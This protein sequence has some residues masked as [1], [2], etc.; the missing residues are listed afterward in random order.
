MVFLKKYQ[1]N[2]YYNLLKII[3]KPI[4]TGVIMMYN[5]STDNEEE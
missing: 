5:N 4:D 1:F 3:K 2:F